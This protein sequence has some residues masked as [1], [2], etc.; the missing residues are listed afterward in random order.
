MSQHGPRIPSERKPRIERRSKARVVGLQTLLSRITT[1]AQREHRKQE[2]AGTHSRSFAI[3]MTSSA[4]D[5]EDNR[6]DRQHQGQAR[7]IQF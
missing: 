1:T 6:T 4:K 7:R 2:R 3:D 5:A